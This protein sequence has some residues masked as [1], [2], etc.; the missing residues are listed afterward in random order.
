MYAPQVPRLRE[1]LVGVREQL[2]HNAEEYGALIEG[3]PGRW[4]LS[5][6]PGHG[7]PVLW[8]YYSLT[9]TTCCLEHLVVP[10]VDEP[11]GPEP[12]MTIL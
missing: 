7:A 4:C 12:D 11:E 9:P 1:I 10:G 2:A 3:K 8:V 5:T 6:F